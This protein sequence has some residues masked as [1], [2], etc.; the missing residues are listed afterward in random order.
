MFSYINKEILFP[1]VCIT[2]YSI[3]IG[4]TICINK[5]YCKVSSSINNYIYTYIHKYIVCVYV[6]MYVCM[7]VFMYIIICTG[8][9]T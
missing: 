4:T 6:C 9:A 2:L 3:E 7:Y 5:I 8:K 1:H